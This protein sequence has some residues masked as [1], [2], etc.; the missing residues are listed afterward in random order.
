ML[1]HKGASRIVSAGY[2]LPTE[3]VTTTSM[4]D[5]VKV[6]NYGVKTD[7]IVNST[8]VQEVRHASFGEQ[9]S[10]LA[11]EAALDAFDKS[12]IK[13][14]QIDLVIFCGI[15]RDY[16][17]PSTAHFVQAKLGCSGVCFDVSNACL[18]AM[19]G[20]QIAN[21]MIG[22]GAVQH[23]LV[24]T[25]ERQCDVAKSVINELRQSNDQKLFKTKVGA[26]TVGDAGSA[27]ILGPKEGRHGIQQMAYE[28]YGEYAKLCYY[29]VDGD[30]IDGAMIMDKICAVMLKS[31]RGMYR[32]TL[33]SLGWADSSIDCGIVHQVGR[34]PWEKFSQI[35]NIPIDK[36]TK[37]FDL[38]G[39]IT[40]NTFLLNYARALEENKISAGSSVFGGLAGS[41]YT[42]CQIGMVV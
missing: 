26:L 19:S 29:K 14:D 12:D 1:I 18:G 31:H 27:V 9:P 23:A 34:R 2:Y 4:L 40:S 22:S 37:T 28:S 21:E 5:E 17:E 35:F 38:L 8:G 3:R 13:P 20:I 25:G 42:S 24:C 10:D 30:R 16:C 32:Q 15:D 7:F 36:M 6:E 11:V 33:Q 41:G 39:N